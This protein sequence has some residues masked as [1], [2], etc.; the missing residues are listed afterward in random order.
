VLYDVLSDLDES[1]QPKGRAKTALSVEREINMNFQYSDKVAKMGEELV[2]LT[3]AEA[4]SLRQYLHQEHEVRCRW[5][6]PQV[7]NV[8]QYDNI[9]VKLKDEK[10]TMDV[11]LVKVADST[12]KIGIIKSVRELTGLGLKEAKDIVDQ[13]PKVVKAGIMTEDAWAMK[14]RLETEGATIELK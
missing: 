1:A 6:E 13:A 8:G 2:A 7:V 3:L 11:V 5:L 4:A 12:K 9:P 10:S 14:K